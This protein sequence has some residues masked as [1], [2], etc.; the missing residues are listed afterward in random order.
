MRSQ[1][2]SEVSGFVAPHLA[3]RYLVERCD[4]NHRTRLS[5]EEPTLVTVAVSDRSLAGL[6]LEAAGIELGLLLT[7]L[8]TLQGLLRLRRCKRQ[9]RGGV[10]GGQPHHYFVEAHP[11]VG[12]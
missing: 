7:G 12:S 1:P 8:R 11:A 6:S 9:D 10:A 2:W 4:F 3:Q 5:R